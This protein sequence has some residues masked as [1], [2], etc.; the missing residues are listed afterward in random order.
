MIALIEAYRNGLFK[1]KHLLPNLIAGITVGIIALPLAMAFAM[2][3]GMKPEQGLYTAI[4]AALTVGIF[5]GSRVQIAGPTG[6]FVVIL[7][8]I[9]NQYGI[10]GLQIATL[11]AGFIL[12]LI[13]FV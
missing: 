10:S 9:V 8:N 4:V 7:L 3:S 2:A 12:L 13:G 1:P 5:G 11:L 6:A